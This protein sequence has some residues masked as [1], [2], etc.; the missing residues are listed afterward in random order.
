MRIRHSL[1]VR[2]LAL[3]LAVFFLL[4]A[5]LFTILYRSARDTV[6]AQEL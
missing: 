3:M 4:F 5:C 2:A 1:L 6:R